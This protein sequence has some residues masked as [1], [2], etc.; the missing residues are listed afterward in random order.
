MISSRYS[1]NLKFQESERKFENLNNQINHSFLGF[2]RNFSVSSDELKILLALI[3]DL[4][5]F[6]GKLVDRNELV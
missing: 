1:K 6:F 3:S 5:I 2:I 4:N